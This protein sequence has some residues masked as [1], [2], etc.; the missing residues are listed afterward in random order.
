MYAQDLSVRVRGEYQEMPGLRLTSR[1]ASRLWNIEHSL[2][3]KVIRELLHAGFLTELWDGSFVS[4]ATTE[5]RRRVLRHSF[6]SADA[7]A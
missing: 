1:Q 4:T 5:A 6:E 3:Q 2:C 7:L